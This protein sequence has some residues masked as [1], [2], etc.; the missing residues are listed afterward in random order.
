MAIGDGLADIV[1]RRYGSQKWFL[2]PN[3]SYAGS[4]AFATGAFVGTSLVLALFSSTGSL[5]MDV[6]A[7]LP[8]VLLISV[9]CALVEL[10]PLGRLDDN[11]SV[12]LAAALLAKFLL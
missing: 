1:G 3:K 5:D 8:I 12:P 4:A 9:L 10:L 2:S 6:A 7:K 11:V